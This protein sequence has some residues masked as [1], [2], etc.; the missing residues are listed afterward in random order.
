MNLKSSLHAVRASIVLSLLCALVS[1]CDKSV[2]MEYSIQCPQ[3]LLEVANPVITY[4]FNGAAEQSITL[5]SSSD[6][7]VAD[8]GEMEWNGLGYHDDNTSANSY[9]FLSFKPIAS[10]DTTSMGKWEYTFGGY[11]KVKDDGESSTAPAVKGSY[12]KLGKTGRSIPDS[13]GISITVEGV[14]NIST[15]VYVNNHWSTYSSTIVT[16]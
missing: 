8:S 3:G 15:N 16:K 1:S 12:Y 5:T 14:D 2:D 10:A 11:A 4:S 6:W 9:A 7:K 13:L